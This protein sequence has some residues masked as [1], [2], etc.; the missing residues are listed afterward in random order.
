MTTE[1][2]RDVQKTV[3]ANLQ[4][5]TL[6][7]ATMKGTIVP[8]HSVFCF[9]GG[10]AGSISQGKFFQISWDCGTNMVDMSEA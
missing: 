9:H 2:S 3:I 7:V 5:R 10:I 4:G 1:T 8:I 6:A